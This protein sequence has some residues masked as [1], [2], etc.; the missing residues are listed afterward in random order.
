DADLFMLQVALAA[1]WNSWGVVADFFVADRNGAAA[2]AYLAGAVSLE[3]G[4]KLAIRCSQVIRSPGSM[5]NSLA[6]LDELRRDVQTIAVR[7]PAVGLFATAT[8]TAVSRDE[9]ANP[10]F[11][12]NVLRQSNSLHAA[13]CAV[14]SEDITACIELG[15]GAD[16]SR[17]G[18]ALF[19]N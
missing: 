9:L 18:E 11:W 8:G 3:H 12:G 10:E 2:A 6:A 4:L 17:E 19:S 15:P 7:R 16:F 5:R 13:L 1:L 14:R